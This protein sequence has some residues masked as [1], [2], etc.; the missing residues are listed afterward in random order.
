MAFSAR[1]RLVN[2]HLG[3]YFSI[4]AALFVAAFLLDLIFEQ[5]GV[6]DGV[7]RIVLLLAPFAL[8]MAIGASTYTQ[9]VFCLLYTSPSPR[10]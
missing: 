9:D 7:L 2:P 4:F 6:S 5:L 1:S 10:D 3:T 8:Y